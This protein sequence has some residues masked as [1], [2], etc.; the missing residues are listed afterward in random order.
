MVKEIAYTDEVLLKA[1]KGIKE[2]TDT[3]YGYRVLHRI[4]N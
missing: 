1:I 4:P 2:W 3:T